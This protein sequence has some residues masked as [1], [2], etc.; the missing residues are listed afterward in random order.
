MKI[1]CKWVYKEKVPNT[2]CYK[3]LAKQKDVSDI[4]GEECFNMIAQLLVQKETVRII[5]EKEE[6]N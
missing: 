2:G 1:I 5:F 6:N 4:K 3:V